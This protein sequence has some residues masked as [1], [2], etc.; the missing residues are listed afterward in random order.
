[1]LKAG[2]NVMVGRRVTDWRLQKAPPQTLLKMRGKLSLLEQVPYDAATSDSSLLR[3]GEMSM[4]LQKSKRRE[5]NERMMSPELTDV[6][7][8]SRSHV[9]VTGSNP[10]TPHPQP[11]PNFLSIG[12][13][14]L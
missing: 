6:A 14:I 3:P 13:N 11:H 8:R 1:M 9:P 10:P 2:R 7:L 4:R 12:Y 5:E